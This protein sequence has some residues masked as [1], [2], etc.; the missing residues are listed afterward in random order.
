MFGICC[1]FGAR[2]FDF[3]IFCLLFNGCGPNIHIMTTGCSWGYRTRL[4][5]SFT[6]EQNARCAQVRIKTADCPGRALPAAPWSGLPVSI[7]QFNIIIIIMQN[8]YFARLGFI[9]HRHGSK[10]RN[11]APPNGT[12]AG[13]M[14]RFVMHI[15]ENHVC[16]T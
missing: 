14:F 16:T 4:G 7:I 10:G 6:C 11:M 5:R 2:G 8:H 15:S 1:T 13:F 9:T 3:V 12:I